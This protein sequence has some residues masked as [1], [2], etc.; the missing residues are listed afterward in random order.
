MP[1]YYNPA[2]TAHRPNEV[3]TSYIVGQHWV[4]NVVFA[5]LTNLCVYTFEEHSLS[6]DKPI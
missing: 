5:G 2:N 4:Y 1:G 6:Y 3:L